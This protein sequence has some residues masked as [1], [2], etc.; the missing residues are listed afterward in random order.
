MVEQIRRERTER[1]LKGERDWER[2][3]VAAIEQM[4]AEQRLGRE[5][6]TRRGADTIERIRAERAEQ[7]LQR[8]S[9]DSMKGV[10]WLIPT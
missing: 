8:E 7:R 2:Y 10:A 4:E 6:G 1:R 5:V 9:D 3:A